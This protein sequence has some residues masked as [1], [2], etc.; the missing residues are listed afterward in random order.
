MVNDVTVTLDIWTFEEMADRIEELEEILK[1]V[2]Q[3]AEELGVYADP[4]YKPAPIF[5]K[6]RE[7]L[8]GRDGRV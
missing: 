1:E 4:H 7:V 5:I 6:V 3:W 2:D 8:N